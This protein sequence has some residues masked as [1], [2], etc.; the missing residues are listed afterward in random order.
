MGRGVLLDVDQEAAA[1]QRYSGQHALSSLSRLSPI[2]S[3]LRPDLCHS[4]Q[5]FYV[6]ALVQTDATN[7][8]KDFV[9]SERKVQQ[10]EA[11][12]YIKV[13]A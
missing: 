9:V 8:R 4:T 12:R 1:Q 2:L 6:C 3:P 11:M 10:S 13:G 7:G 5:I